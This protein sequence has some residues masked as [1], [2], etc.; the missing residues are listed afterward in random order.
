VPGVAAPRRVSERLTAFRIHL[1][2]RRPLRSAHGSESVRDV[3]LVCCHL[4]DGTAGWGE[5]PT[6][7]T[8][9]YSSETTDSA[10][11]A[12]LAGGPIGP[13]AAGAVAD[14]RQDAAERAEGVVRSDGRRTVPSCTVV[15]LDGEVPAA[16]AVKL[17]VA[18]VEAERLV[19]VRRRWPD[20]PVAVDANGS[21]GSVE[22]A[23]AVLDALGGVVYFEQPFPRD[24]LDLCAA[25]R[26]RT[27]CVVALD[28]SIGS[29]HDLQVAHG[30]GALDVVSVKP[31]RLGGVAAA[32]EVARSAAELGL[33]WFVGG[34][35]ESGIGR[36]AALQVAARQ[37]PDLPTDLGPSSRYVERDVCAPIVEDADGVVVPSGPGWGRTPDEARL[38]ELTVDRAEL[39]L[40]RP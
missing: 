1:P 11:A 23:A 21:L 12:L 10:W 18:G 37:S 28:E 31:A 32:F 6:L 8:P 13:M 24:R 16:G 34:M 5:C 33:R 36:A 39:P 35:W 38:A 30:A 19:A 40:P 25:L 17:K 27:G 9:G 29:L 26:D 20:R 14:A 7:S 4:D 2:L 22:E 15:D 3:I